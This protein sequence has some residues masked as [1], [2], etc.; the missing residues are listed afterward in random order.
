MLENLNTI[1]QSGIKALIKERVENP[2]KYVD[3]PLVIWRADYR[4]GIQERIL[5]EVFDEYNEARTKEERKWYRTSMLTNEGQILYDFTTPEIIRTDVEEPAFG[6]YNLGLMVIEPVFVTMD[7]NKGSLEMYYSA[8]NNR[9]VGD[10]RLLPGVPVVAFMS[11]NHAWFETPERY[12]DAEQYI[13]KPDFEEW[14][15]WA[16]NV[17]KF[18][19]QIIDFIR[20]NGDKEGIIFRWY[21]YFNTTHE[22]VRAG[23][24]YPDHWNDLRIC[25]QEEMKEAEVN[26]ISALSFE[27]LKNVCE[28]NNHISDDVKEALCKYITEH[29][30]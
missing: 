29:K 14:V 5:E 24:D 30:N 18:P 22:G 25:L 10:V 23:C 9:R 1:D 16:L 7:Y 17:K 28:L 27:Q 20:G 3:T 21:N 8:I 2:E 4:D 13:F 26:S 11:D 15:E 6:K 12:P 19:H